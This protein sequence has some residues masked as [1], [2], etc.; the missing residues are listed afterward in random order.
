M[1]V[2]V[3][4]RQVRFVVRGMEAQG[5]RVISPLETYRAGP[6]ELKYEGVTLHT[7]AYHELPRVLED[8]ILN[9]FEPDAKVINLAGR[10]EGKAILAIRPEC[11]SSP[12][13]A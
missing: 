12:T 4:Q 3:G 9:N 7:V 10:K 1:E 13:Y 6:E 8:L 5:A 11:C 2:G